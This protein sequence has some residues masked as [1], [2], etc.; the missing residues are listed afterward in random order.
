MPR[1]SAKPK[2]LTLVAA[3]PADAPAIIALRCEVAEHLAAQFGGKGRSGVG[4]EKGVLYAMR[5]SRVLVARDGDRVAAS[6]TLSTRKPWAIDA[7][8]FTPCRKP[9][10]LT[11]MLVSPDLQ[12]GGVGR[13]CLEEARRIAREWPADAIRLD[14]FDSPSGAGGFYEKCG[15]VEVGRAVYRKSKLIYYEWVVP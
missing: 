2:P 15:F 14:A 9:V 6:L 4:T 7:R 12:R 3:T 11:D 13:Q 1:K 10:Y 5:I 8:Y